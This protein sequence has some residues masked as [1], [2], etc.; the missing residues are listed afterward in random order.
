[1]YSNSLRLDIFLQLTD[2]TV[3]LVVETPEKRGKEGK[4]A[5]KKADVR[6]QRQTKGIIV[7]SNVS[8]HISRQQGHCLDCYNC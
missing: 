3:S 1:M 7:D 8:G 6:T 2:D 5:G 4:V